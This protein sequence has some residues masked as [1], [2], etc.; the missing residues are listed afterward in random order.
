LAAIRG[1]EGQQPP[2]AFDIRGIEYLPTDAG[3][4][5]DARPFHQPEMGG[6]GRGRN[7]QPRGDRPGR[8]AAGPFDD[9]NPEN[10]EPGL[11]REG[12][13]AAYGFILFHISENI[14]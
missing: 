13:K 7:V 6:E 14:E 9:K 2:Y 10:P 4:P 12:R 5:Q 11:V 8:Q 1:Q 3:P